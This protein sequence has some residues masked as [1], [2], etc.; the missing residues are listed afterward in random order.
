M[1]ES[2]P[3]NVTIFPLAFLFVYKSR[4]PLS[5]Y[6]HFETHLVSLHSTL[7]PAVLTNNATT[8]FQQHLVQVKTWVACMGLQFKSKQRST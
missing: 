7:N 4:L 1:Y 3:T 8:V 6:I 2:L 5:K